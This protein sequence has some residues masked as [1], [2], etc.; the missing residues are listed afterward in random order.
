MPTIFRHR[1][2][3]GDL[4]A[5]NGPVDGAQL[6]IDI[7]D[8]WRS[9]PEV[10]PQLNPRGAADGAYGSPKWPSQERYLTVGGWYNAFGDLAAAERISDRI[11]NAFSTS[12][13]LLTRW[14]ATPK[15][16]TVRHYGQVVF[17]DELEDASRWEATLV[18]PYPFKVGLESK[19][20]STFGFAGGEYFRTYPRTYSD[21]YPNRTYQQVAGSSATDPISFNNVGTAT[22]LPEITI[23]G[24]LESGAWLLVN[25]TTG[26]QMWAYTSLGVGQVLTINT[27]TMKAYQD[28]YDVSHLVFG[29]WF[30]L[31]PGQNVI[32]LYGAPE[33]YAEIREAR[34]AWK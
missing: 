24:P 14:E 30:G 7:L 13:F 12:D 8:G 6:G 22:Y 19:S 31:V 5:N 25:E 2:D 3:I 23:N 32:R 26:E 34:S 28:G 16:L 20:L 1:V 21:P 18:A 9:T 17:F 29:E 33:A 4:T 11:V 10:S 27:R 15:S